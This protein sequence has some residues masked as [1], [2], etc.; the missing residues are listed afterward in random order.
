MIQEVRDRLQN[1]SE[2]KKKKRL[3]APL[4]VSNGKGKQFIPSFQIIIYINII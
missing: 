3:F 4:C 1:L 2:K